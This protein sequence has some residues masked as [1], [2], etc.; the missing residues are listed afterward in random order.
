M[1]AQGNLFLLKVIHNPE[2][3]GHSQKVVAFLASYCYIYTRDDANA[4]T[5]PVGGALVIPHKARLQVYNSAF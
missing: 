5:R 3:M 1:K 4:I 2:T